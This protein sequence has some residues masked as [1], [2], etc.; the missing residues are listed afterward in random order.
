MKLKEYMKFR[1]IYKYYLNHGTLFFPS[2]EV[3][4]HTADL[5]YLCAKGVIQITPYQNGDPDCRVKISDKGL[6]YRDEVLAAF[7]Q[8]FVP[9]AISI[10]ALIVSI[11]NS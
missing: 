1:K 3:G 7:F 2:A 9:T 8:Y 5:H 11:V 6:I 4:M 10:A